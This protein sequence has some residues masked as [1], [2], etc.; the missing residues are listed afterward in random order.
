MH[1]GHMT[2]AS[3]CLTL[4]RWLTR[5]LRHTQVAGQRLQGITVPS[6]VD[7]FWMRRWSGTEADHQT[8][9]KLYYLIL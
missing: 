7:S 2:A 6:A 9:F 3:Q 8:R 1:Q 5:S 4:T